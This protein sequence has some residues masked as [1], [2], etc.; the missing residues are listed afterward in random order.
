MAVVLQPQ[1]NTG[2]NLPIDTSDPEKKEVVSNSAKSFLKIN[3][4]K[5]C[6]PFSQREFSFYQSAQ[7]NVFKPFIP[8]FY[9]P[10]RVKDHDYIELGDLL[11][12]IKSPCIADIKLGNHL[13]RGIVDY[14]V[15]NHEQQLEK[16]MKCTSG[17]L[18]FRIVGLQIYQ[19]G[20]RNFLKKDG[21]WGRQLSKETVKDGLK[22]F[23]HNGQSMRK[24]V[25]KLFEEK[26]QE[27][28][29]CFREQRLFRF[30]AC[31]LMFVYEGDVML[32]S[33]VEMKM[34]DFEH[35]YEVLDGG[36]DEGFLTGLQNL[37]SYFCTLIDETNEKL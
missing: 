28:I 19:P 22:Q 17:Q 26:L 8:G 25:I 16:S 21:L 31:S 18:Y 36:R 7:N 32:P 11:D 4:G 12:G 6:K 37:A 15:D 23:F 24:E 27:L 14:H 5:I 30:Y 13:K 34:I 33:K 20:T 35:A 2:F 1:I 10:L 9:G 29:K 3:E